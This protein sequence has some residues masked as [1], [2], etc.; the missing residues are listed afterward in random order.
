MGDFV[1]G[2]IKGKGTRTWANESVYDG[3]FEQG[4]KNGYGEMTYSF[5]QDKK[6]K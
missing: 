2:E 6:V 1:N 4:E 3:D 5:S